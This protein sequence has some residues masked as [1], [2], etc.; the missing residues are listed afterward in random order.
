MNGAHDMGGMHGFGAVSAQRDEPIFHGDWEART[1]A[2]RRAVG[3][4]GRWN[5]DAGRHGVER[6]PPADYLRMTYYEKWLA[7]METMLV[8][9]GLLTAEELATGRKAPGSQPNT[10]PLTAARVATVIAAGSPSSRSTAAKPRFEAGAKVRAKNINPAGHTRLPRY[11]RGHVGIVER[12]HGAHVL[13]DSNAG[14]RGES[15]EFLYTVRFSAP[16]LW[17]PAANPLDSIHL[18]LWESYLDPA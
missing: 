14:F 3:A 12:H 9:H 16:E 11:V 8:E 13:P 6:L 10:P 1:Y 4:W 17:G 7:S 15:P 5:I 2:M 18:D